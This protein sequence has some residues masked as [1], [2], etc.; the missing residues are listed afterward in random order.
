MVRFEQKIV[1]AYLNKFSLFLSLLKADEPVA[2][3]QYKVQKK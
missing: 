1:S 3:K 2:D